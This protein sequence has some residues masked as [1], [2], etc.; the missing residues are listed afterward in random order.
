[1]SS[2]CILYYNLNNGK[3]NILLGFISLNQNTKVCLEIKET[4]LEF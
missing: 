3:T 4:I 1:M 2:N